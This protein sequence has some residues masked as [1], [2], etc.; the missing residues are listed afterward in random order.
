MINVDKTESVENLKYLKFGSLNVNGLKNR[1]NY[2]EFVEFIEKHDIFCVLETHLNDS[3]IV[4]IDGYVFF[5]KHRSQ[6]YKRKSGGIGIYVRENIALFVNILENDTEYTLW[7]NINKHITNF[8]NDIVLGAV[9]LPPENSRFLNEDELN[10]FETEITRMCSE[11]KY[12]YLAGD[13][14]AR[15]SQLNDFI[16]SDPFLNDYFD[17]DSES[18]SFLDKYT[19]LEN[20]SIPLNRSS[21][22][23]KTNSHGI[24]LIELCRNNNLFILNGRIG[25]DQTL[26]SFTFRDRSIIDYVCAT[27]DCFQYISEFEII[28]TDPLYSDG[29]SAL[30]WSLTVPDLTNFR[31]INHDY[32]QQYPKWQTDMSTNFINNIDLIQLEEIK[33]Q[34][35]TNPQS[36]I[37][38]EHITNELQQ[39]FEKSAHSTFQPASNK[40]KHTNKDNKPWFGPK[41]FQARNN[42]ANPFW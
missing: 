30:Y 38:I 15:T 17:I 36:Q 12:V 22:D 37:T 19:I 4:D 40:H 8:D 29:H 14:N 25:K 18:Q 39:L 27:A 13:V 6:V 26:R 23:R 41:C 5:A 34:L 35:N 21:S 32:K 1:L 28:E 9:Y 11:H 31:K 10:Y 42:S 2:P 20:L 16:P 33:L 24:K 3:D 7:I